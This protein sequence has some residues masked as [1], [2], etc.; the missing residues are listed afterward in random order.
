MKAR[1]L[2]RGPDAAASVTASASTG[3]SSEVALPSL[4]SAAGTSVAEVSLLLTDI[5]DSTH[6]WEQHPDLMAIA[7]VRHEAIVAGAIAEHGGRLVKNRGEGDSALAVFDSPADALDAALGLHAHLAHESWPGQLPIRTRMG[8]HAGP[9]QVHGD[10]VFG[11]TVNLAGRLRGV[12][13]G[14][15]VVCSGSFADAVAPVAG[16]RFVLHD[17][18]RQA[19]K[20]V[21]QPE[22]VML[23]GPVIATGSSLPAPVAQPLVGPASGGPMAASAA[24]PRFL[25][26][27]AGSLLVGRAAELAHLRRLWQ[28][29]VAGDSA[30]VVVS[31]EA[32]IGKTRLVAELAAGVSAAGG[33]VLGTQCL[34]RMLL[35][36]EPI[37]A[38]VHQALEHVPDEDR[39]GWLAPMLDELARFVPG[40][41]AGDPVD[42]GPGDPELAGFLL[43]RAVRDLLVELAGRR[44]VLGVVEDL[45]LMDVATL[46][47]LD[48]LAFGEPL[49]GVMLVGTVRDTDLAIGGDLAARL[50]DLDARHGARLRLDGLALE[51][52]AALWVAEA[53]PPRFATTAADVHARTGG[54]PFFTIETARHAVESGGSGAASTVPSSVRGVLRRRLGRLPDHSREV[55]QAASVLGATVRLDLLAA[56]LDEDEA[57]VARRARSSVRRPAD[58]RRQRAGRRGRVRARA[59]AGG[60][61]RRRGVAAAAR[62]A[63]PGGRGD[64]GAGRRRQRSRPGVAGEP[65][66]PRRGRADAPAPMRGVPRRSPSDPRPSPTPPSSP[67]WRCSR[68]RPTG[69]RRASASSSSSRPRASGRSPARTRP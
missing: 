44:P 60:A 36:Y 17:L 6:L 48:H 2:D 51:E 39:A 37:T 3:P 14:G 49:P 67:S 20:G 63:P 13:V 66:G 10:D 54:N 18:G 43:Y 46:V 45:Q 59:G 56:A 41:A 19:L 57:D 26:P 64:R 61:V 27:R 55:L 21:R 34:E 30:S 8:L 28:Q 40:V 16:G 53:G 15:Q 24:L 12:A 33:I 42:T 22:R 23:V 25:R 1:N 38:L 65:L 47:V 58:R 7:L 50:D 62:P 52:S 9:V 68:A 35:P 11:P 5:A 32:G 31:G 4:T 29:A 69:R